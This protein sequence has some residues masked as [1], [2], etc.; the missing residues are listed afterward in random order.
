MR[1][2]RSFVG[3]LSIEGLGDID[4]AYEYVE[5]LLPLIGEVV[6]FF[7]ALESD[8]NDLLC[9]EISDRTDQRGLLVLHNMGYQSKLELYEQFS[10]D[11]LRVMDWDVPEFDP[12]IASMKEVGA[13]RNRV[14]HANWHYTDDEGFTQVRIRWGKDGLE[15]E[16]WNFTVESMEDILEKILA[17]RTALDEFV[18]RI[19]ELHHERS[20]EIDARLAQMRDEDR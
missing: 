20:R 13:L 12:L 10:R 9:A 11:L 18:I 1:S 6:L 2:K 3:Q 7:N 4:N 14:V 8:L 17:T 16:L 5:E 19:E 15:H